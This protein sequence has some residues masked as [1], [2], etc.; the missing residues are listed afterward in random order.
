LADSLKN[1]LNVQKEAP[2]SE[3]C[4]R[5]VNRKA[6]LDAVKEIAGPFMEGIISIKFR[7]TRLF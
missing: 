4:R 6:E 3:A 7:L 5:E 1:L 2:K